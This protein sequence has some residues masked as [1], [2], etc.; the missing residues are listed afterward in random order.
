MKGLHGWMRVLEGNQAAVLS[1]LL[2]EMD[3][4]T[5]SDESSGQ[6]LADII[7]KDA[8]LTASIIRIANSV[9]YN[10]SD[11]SV[12]TVSRAILNIGFKNIRSICMSI[13]VLEA[14]LKES[15]SPM[16]VAMLAKSLHGANQ[17]KALCT[18]LNNTKRE[19]VFIAA[20]LSHLAEL[21][22]L[23]ANETE[24]KLLRNDIE[25][26]S[27][28]EDKNRYA[29]KHLGVSLTRLAKTLM[30]QWRIDGMVHDV[31]SPSEEPESMVEAVLLGQEISRTA[32]LGWDSPEFKEVMNR[33]AEFKD[34]SPA[35][36]EKMVINVADETAETIS[37]FGKKILTDYIPTSKKQAKQVEKTAKV[38][39]KLLSASPEIQLN[40]LQDLSELMMTQFNIN[41]VFK[42]VLKGLN[43]GV[44]LERVTLAIFDKSQ[45]KVVAKYVAGSG[46]EKWKEKFIVPY[47]R[48]RSGFLYSLFEGDQVAW[49]GNTDFK[50]ISQYITP[51]YHGI[52]GQKQFFI[53]PLKADKR[54]IGFIYADM[55]ASSRNL[56][57]EQFDGFKRFVQQ[58][59]LALTI[60]AAR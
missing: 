39:S 56:S 52:T 7:L 38:E 11:I 17:S 29:E 42:A 33:V 36:A 20:L 5:A 1:T 3:R 6:Q 60:L 46:T 51:E 28:N 35:D 31:I 30:K 25:V 9:T 37:T 12:T 54:R 15:P 55:G 47:E 21:L 57:N 2:Q 45:Q 8:S 41:A 44:G 27:K 26:T 14:V 34:V 19:E 18:K 49:I 22:V 4:V 16:L 13:K 32:I 10:P 58:I 59:K 48:N 43:Q 53:A 23:G 24:V 50:E 40:T